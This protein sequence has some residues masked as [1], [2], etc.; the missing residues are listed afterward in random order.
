VYVDGKLLT[1]LRGEGIVP[2]FLA[3]LEE[4]VRTRYPSRQPE[5]QTG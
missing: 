2:E 3:I 4:Y 5:L 1:T